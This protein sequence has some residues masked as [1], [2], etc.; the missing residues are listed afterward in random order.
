MKKST[1]LGQLKK[2]RLQAPFHSTRTGTKPKRAY[3]K[4]QTNI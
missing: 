3:A 2:N 1:T 4:L